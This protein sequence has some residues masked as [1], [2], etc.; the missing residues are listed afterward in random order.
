MLWLNYNNFPLR[1]REHFTTLLF[2]SLLRITQCLTSPHSPDYSH[3]T[4]LTILAIDLFTRFIFQLQWV[5][6][7][8]NEVRQASKPWNE[9]LKMGSGINCKFNSDITRNH[10]HHFNQQFKLALL[11]R[12]SPCPSPPTLHPSSFHHHFTS[13]LSQNKVFVQ[14]TR[15]WK[16]CRSKESDLSSKRGWEIFPLPSILQSRHTS[17][18]CAYETEQAVMQ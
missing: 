11:S 17:N 13:F 6:S 5:E 15:F 16:H 14:Q 3:H 8:C 10:H 18:T 4:Q 12:T 2:Q 7:V 9:Q 1:K